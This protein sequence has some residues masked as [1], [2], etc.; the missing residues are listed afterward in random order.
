VINFDVAR[1][2]LIRRLTSRRV[3]GAAGGLQ[4]DFKPP[5]KADTCDACGAQ[6]VQRADDREET[7]IQ[8]LEVYARQ[9]APLIAYYRARGCWVEIDGNA[10]YDAAGADRE[11]ARVGADR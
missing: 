8:R 1:A 9:T 4:L 11:R 10:G 7:V 3:C 6:L 2:E 5:R